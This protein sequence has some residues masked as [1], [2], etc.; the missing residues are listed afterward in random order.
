MARRQRR[1]DPVG[2][3]RLLPS[4]LAAAAVALLAP[5]AAHAAVSPPAPTGLAPFVFARQ[6]LVDHHRSESLVPGG[7][8]RRVPVRVWYPAARPGDAPARVFTPAEQKAWE[9]LD[10][11]P[12]ASLD[13]LGAAATSGAVPAP[14]RHRVLLLSHGLGETTAFLTSHAADLASH[15]YVVVGI[16]HPGDASAVEVAR[17]RLA[18]KS[19]ATTRH[20]VRAVA[21]RVADLRFVA[22][23]LR[24][25]RGVGRLRVDR[26]GAVGH[27]MGGA[28]SAGA[29]L[30][31]RRIAAGVD[32]DGSLFG[33]VVRRGL[34]EP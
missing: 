4:A 23:R 16:D 9:S 20:K 34:D 13:G 15:G 2:M 26:V 21:T 30:A 32:M 33:P 31:D 17:G 11:L 5:G 28:A 14:G 27:S 3:R 29:M 19:P 18:M 24:T 1:R 7:G 12:P 10:G 22:G 25:L 6:T 8:P